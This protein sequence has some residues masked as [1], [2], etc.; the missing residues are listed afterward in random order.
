MYLFRIAFNGGT[1]SLSVKNL[2]LR[3]RAKQYARDFSMT[4]TD[5]IES[6]ITDLLHEVYGDFRGIYVTYTASDSAYSYYVAKP[7]F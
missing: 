5:Q 6:I 1:S 3:S 2:S 7:L 4:Q